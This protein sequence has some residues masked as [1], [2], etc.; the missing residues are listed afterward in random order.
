MEIKKIK[1]KVKWIGTDVNRDMEQKHSNR[2]INK[3]NSSMKIKY[4][5]QA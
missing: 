3:N 5:F 2:K 1:R 4:R